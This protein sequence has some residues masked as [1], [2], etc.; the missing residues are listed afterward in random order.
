MYTFAVL[1]GNFTNICTEA[2]GTKTIL[3]G[4]GRRKMFNPA[5]MNS[6]IRIE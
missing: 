3:S 1:P 2:S 6:L 4:G 5:L